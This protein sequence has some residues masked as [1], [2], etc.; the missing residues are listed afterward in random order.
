ML[1]VEDFPDVFSEEFARKCDRLAKEVCTRLRDDP[2]LIG[3]FYSDT[4]NWPLWA[5][6][7]GTAKLLE[8][9]KKTLSNLNS[10]RPW[11][12]PAVAARGRRPAIWRYSELRPWLCE[13]FP[14]RKGL[15]PGVYGE[16]RSRITST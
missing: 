4:P 9:A 16:A 10:T 15:L 7:V 14:D 8:V 12:K 6:R 1:S 5:E 3:Y 11:P 13:T 2:Y